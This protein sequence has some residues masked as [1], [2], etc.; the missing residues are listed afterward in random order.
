VS[1]VQSPEQQM[2]VEIFSGNAWC[3][4]APDNTPYHR[5]LTI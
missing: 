4:N 2:L 1:A 3:V 5:S